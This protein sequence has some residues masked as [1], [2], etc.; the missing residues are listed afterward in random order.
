MARGRMKPQRDGWATAQQPRLIAGTQ[1]PEESVAPAQRQ[2]EAERLRAD[3]EAHIAAGG[4]YLQLRSPVAPRHR[5]R[6]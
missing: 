4:T 5:G 2:R 3:V 1:L 6:A